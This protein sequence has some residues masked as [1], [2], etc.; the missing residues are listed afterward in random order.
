[1]RKIATAGLIALLAGG[2][3]PLTRGATPAYAQESPAEERAE[4]RADAQARARAEWAH[5]LRRNPGLRQ[6]PQWLDNPTYRKNHPLIIKWLEQHPYVLRESR[7]E[8]MWDPDGRWR[9]SFWW[10]QNDP[11]EFWENHPEWAE[12]H[13][14]WRGAND[15]DWDD[16][17]N[18][19]ARN[20]WIEHHRDWVEDH[21][22]GWLRH[23]AHEPLQHP[24]HDHDDD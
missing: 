13:Q 21:H 11:D 12:R 15:G 2:A 8:G 6:H 1:M 14:D 5:W 9:D 18:W 20:W 3:L 17:H 16:Q 19:R 7:E 23:K 24:G 10:H 4:A 22:P